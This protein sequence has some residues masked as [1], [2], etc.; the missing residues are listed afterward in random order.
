DDAVAAPDPARPPP[1]APRALLAEAP[2]VALLTRG[3]AGALVITR[4]DAVPVNVPARLVVDTIG[5]GDAFSGG[6]L[7]WWSL[8]NLTAQDV[9]DAATVVDAARFAAQV[10]SRTVERAGASP[11]YLNALEAPAPYTCLP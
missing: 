10:A 11:P 8:R 9:A 6:F 5:A 4:H 3:A 7:A 2:S 1:E